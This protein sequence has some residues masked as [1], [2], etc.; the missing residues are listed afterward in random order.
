MSDR[1]RLVDQLI[2]NEELR[3]FPY[4]DTVGKITLGVGRNL[5]DNGISSGEAMMLL[6]HDLDE[7]IT[8]LSGSFPW[9][10]P[11]DPVRQRAM[12]D[13]RFNLGHDGFRGFKRMLRMMSEQDY[14]KAA[15]A[16]RDS[17]WFSQVKTRGVRDVRMILT[18][19][20]D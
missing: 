12:V 10:P 20:D 6:D 14:P 16:A 17:L 13:M 1:Q 3:L 8:D 11:L 2:L 19:Q 9:F 15:S 18:G 4:M 7:V 5:S